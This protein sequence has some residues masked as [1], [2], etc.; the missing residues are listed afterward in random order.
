M[1]RCMTPLAR[2]LEAIL[3]KQRPVSSAEFWAQVE[4]FKDNPEEPTPASLS[5]F[6]DSKAGL[7]P[8]ASLQPVNG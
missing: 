1:I 4:G 5:S 6:A 3:R 2:Q 8:E 7:K